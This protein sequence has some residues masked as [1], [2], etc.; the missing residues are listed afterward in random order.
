MTKNYSD[1]DDFVPVEN[2]NKVLQIQSFPQFQMCGH[3]YKD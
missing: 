2:E 3:L 1:S